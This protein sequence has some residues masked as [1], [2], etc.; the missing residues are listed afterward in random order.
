MLN[1][2]YVNP[3]LI[4]PKTKENVREQEL[5]KLT[6]L[7]KDGF[8]L[9]GLEMTVPEL[10]SLCDVNIDPQHTEQKTT[11]SCVKEIAFNFYK[12]FAPAKLYKNEKILFLTNR[13]D[14]D[15]ISSYLVATKLIKHEE[16]SYLY[17][18]QINSHDTF[19]TLPWQKEKTIEEA[20][21]PNSKTSALA[22]TIKPFMV[23]EDNI[24]AVEKFLDT[25]TVDDSIMSSYQASQQNII[26]KVKSGEIKVS[27]KGGIA[28]VETTLPCA[29]NV[30]YSYAPV[31]IA[32]NPAMHNPDGSTYK[33]ISI[34]QH[35]QGYVD[36]QAVKEALLLKEQGWGGSPTFIGSPQGT[37]TTITTEE[38]QK[39]VYQNLTQ[40][41]K[42]KVTSSTKTPPSF[43]L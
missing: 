28:T 21:N 11:Q 39:L 43:E 33:K 4:N 38:L 32:I 5:K 23:T 26:N 13:V 17:I 31:V 14:L 36:L 12:V 25:G 42:T 1:F 40:D 19:Q 20:F 9:I 3:A 24:K 8:T 2:I 34:C 30:G 29:T 6:Q 41:Y 22:S 37:S 18:Q 7:K 15:S 35:E 10:A 16:I 27:K